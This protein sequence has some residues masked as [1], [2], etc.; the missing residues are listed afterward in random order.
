MQREKY[1][2][3]LYRGRYAIVWTEGSRTRRVSTGAKDESEAT[4]FLEDWLRALD[5]PETLTVANL[6]AAYTK[7][8]KG[9]ATL[10]R[11]GSEWKALAPIFEN[12]EPYQITVDH[13]RAHT[14]SRRKN[15]I[16][17]G[18]IWTELGDLATVLSWARKRRYITETPYIERPAKPPAKTR[19]LRENEIRRLIDAAKEP[20]IELAIMLMLTT[21]GRSGA[22][23]ELTWDRVDF[24]H[25]LIDLAKFS[26]QRRKGR[27]AVPINDDLLPMLERAKRA[28]LSDH[29][30]EWAGRPVKSIKRGFKAAVIAADLEG[31]TPHTLRHTAA[32]HMAKRGISMEM[33]AQY[34]GHEDDRITQRVYARFA[35]DHMRDASAA[36]SD[37]LRYGI[38]PGSS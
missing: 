18:T 5:A 16:L 37:M 25:N 27:A 26:G 9:A 7:E 4:R 34:L 3:K 11:M 10:K 12:L 6:W 14:E 38:P 31:V 17:D 30:I 28:A 24:N 32:V 15:G 29:V 22:V 35:P 23:L 36:L 33:I 8:K 21:A 20:H 1:K 19:W 2:L 13:C